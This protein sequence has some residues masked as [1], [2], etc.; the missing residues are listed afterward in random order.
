MAT[1][2]LA[3]INETL[4]NVDDNT[5][6]TSTGIA[7]FLSYL[8][9][10]DA[11]DAKISLE[12]KRESTNEKLKLGG[13]SKIKGDGAA[14]GFGSLSN[15]VPNF[16]KGLSLGAIASALPMIAKR[17]LGNVFKGGA[18]IAFADWI[19]DN[20][21]PDGLSNS[22]F[23]DEIAGGLKGLGFSLLLGGKF[24]ALFTAIGALLGNK[25]FMKNLDGLKGDL[26]KLAKDSYGKLEPTLKELSES[27]TGL[28]KAIFGD[29]TLDG[30]SG[31]IVGVLEPLAKAA[32]ESLK[33]LKSLVLGDFDIEKILKAVGL[34]G[35][36]GGLLMPG[37]FLKL[38]YKLAALAATLGGGALLRLAST[39]GGALLS[40]ALSFFAGR[41]AMDLAINAVP[42]AKDL[43][44]DNRTKTSSKRSALSRLF[45]LLKS[46]AAGAFGLMTSATGAAILVPLAAVGI[47]EALFGDKLRDEDQENKAEQRSNNQTGR[48]SKTGKDFGV[49]KF[50][51][52]SSTDL[53]ESKKEKPATI[54][55]KDGVPQEENFS[56]P[57]EDKFSDVTGAFRK[58]IKGN[59]LQEY[60]VGKSGAK[61]T[62]PI[63][64]SGNKMNNTFKGM[65]FGVSN[66]TNINA[67]N[68]V[69]SDNT[70]S[71]TNA[72]VSNTSVSSRG[73]VLD[74]Q[75]EFG[76]VP[77]LTRL[78]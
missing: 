4:E 13:L 62:A 2:T 70:T 63:V 36:I 59:K 61:I 5:K 20:L 14:F 74:L 17:L 11:K 54:T 10:K 51:G 56:N 19:V 28:F 27:F 67:G 46:G 30:I 25:E 1:I 39:A 45:G 38:L 24:K 31:G 64:E 6:K 40:S 71:T 15:L 76:F 34:L 37:K 21:L 50:G 12:E 60:F 75:D 72:N 16:L 73:G 69:N 26:T 3:T 35:A 57:K 53:I 55:R 66:N 49:T 9:G 42:D 58:R 48:V 33:A 29:V 65:D 52:S 8:K 18:L 7:S 41:K 22:K 44:K 32:N 23:R 43:K 78:A 47:T 68:K 77:N